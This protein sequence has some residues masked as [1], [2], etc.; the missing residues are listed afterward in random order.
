MV[1]VVVAQA[2]SYDQQVV[3]LAIK[4][5]VRGVIQQVKQAGAIPL[6]G[7]SPG[8]SSTVKAAEKCGIL[9]ICQQEGVELVSF[10]E[11]VDVSFPEG[12]TIKKT[13]W[14]PSIANAIKSFR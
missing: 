11:K 1:K 6:V 13:H 2:D 14:P 12:T 4:E 3:E 7:D 5:V 8:V 10:T 9:E